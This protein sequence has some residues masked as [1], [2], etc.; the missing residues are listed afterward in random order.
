MNRLFLAL[1]LLPG[2]GI[3]GEPSPV[4]REE[5]GH[6]MGY[7]GGSGCRFNRNGTWYSAADAAQHLN[8][9]YDYLLRKGLVASAEDFIDRAASESSMS[10][11]PYQVQCGAQAAVSS[12]PWLRAE[13]ARYRAQRR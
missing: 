12:G 9:K 2:A 5:I 13:L 10:G 6:L 8:G 3:A 11:K 7:L 4:A 1:L